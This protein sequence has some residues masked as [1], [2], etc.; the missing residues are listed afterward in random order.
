VRIIILYGGTFF[1]II[2]FS[3]NPKKIEMIFQLIGRQQRQANTEEINMT[4]QP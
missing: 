1:K 2:V 3:L 4:R